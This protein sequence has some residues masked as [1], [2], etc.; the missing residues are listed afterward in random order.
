M[1]WDSALECGV[2]P[3]D[4]EH[5]ELF[6]MVGNLMKE[7]SKETAEETLD[8][9][10]N[11]VVNHF[12]HEEE[13]MGQCSYPRSEGKIREKRWRAGGQNRNIPCGHWLAC[14]SY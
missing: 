13:L 7:S 9:L 4:S 6:K 10:G 11:Y 12:A 8:F 3:V 2:E 1:Q 5:K 14:Q